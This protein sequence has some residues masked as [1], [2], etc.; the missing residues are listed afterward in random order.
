MSFTG[1]KDRVEENDTVILSCLGKLS[2]TIVKKGDMLQNKHGL[3]KHDD[4]IGKPYGSKVYACDRK[5]VAKFMHI[6]HPTPQFWTEVLPHRTQ[7]IYPTDIAMVLYKLD[8][9]PGS[10]VVETGTGSGS[11]SHSFARSV[12]PS[13]HLHTFDFHQGRVEKARE[14]FACHGFSDVVTCKQADATKDGF[15]LDGKCDAVFFDLPAPHLALPFADSALKSSGGRLCS[16]SPCIEQVQRTCAWLH[17]HKYT[18]IQTLQ[19]LER[20][21]HTRT[22]S[23]PDFE[24][25]TPDFFSE[26]TEDGKPKA[27]HPK[28]F[29]TTSKDSALEFLSS[30]HFLEQ[31][32][33]TGY[34]TFATKPHSESILQLSVVSDVGENK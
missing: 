21:L 11:L 22:M 6:L 8:I 20:K 26:D 33:H 32:G 7:I 14:E 17:D 9:K 30:E 18:E 27:K 23:I 19:V 12:Y 28:T 13:G 3:Y 5:N 25:C 34:L 16:F 24:F 2:T 15:G 31:K 10:I 29:S 1:F 4:M